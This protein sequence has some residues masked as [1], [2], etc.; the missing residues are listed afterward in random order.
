VQ[1]VPDA[2]TSRVAGLN[3]TGSVG[4]A[5]K[6]IFGTA[7]NLGGTIVTV[8]QKFLRGAEAQGVT[9]GSIVI[10][11]PVNWRGK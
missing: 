3:E 6:R 7:D 11:P 4:T 5:D 8:D 2:P 10:D 9:F 1:V